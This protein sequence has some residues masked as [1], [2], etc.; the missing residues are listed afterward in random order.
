MINSISREVIFFISTLGWFNGVILGLYFLFVGKKLQLS[1]QL[2]G[3]LLLILSV[4]VSKSVIWYFNPDIPVLFVQIGLGVCFLIAP[5]LYLYVKSVLEDIKQPPLG[6]KI[7]F[8]LCILVIACV[9]IFFTEKHHIPLWK[10]YFVP[11]IYFQWISGVL[12]TGKMLIP[13]LKKSFQEKLQPN[14]KWL[15]VIYLSNL[16]I[17]LN[18][19]ISYM[20]ILGVTY[21]TGAITFS[22][23]LYLNVLL[24]MHRKNKQILLK[25]IQEKYTHKK[26]DEISANALILKLEQVMSQNEIYNNPELKL[27]DLAQSMGVTTHQLSQ[28][29]NDNIKKSF[30]TYLN[31][32]R[33]K[34]ACELLRADP[35]T[36][37]EAI[38]YDVGYQSKSTFFAAF[39][40]VME[41]TPTQFKELHK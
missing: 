5:I 35:T 19:W 34:K 18:Y 31:E 3:V 8:R 37:I 9:L 12:W 30:S 36:K 13:N 27:P 17:V 39:K 24:W 21:I 1:N 23:L 33:I 15:L 28:L 10:K 20:N 16:M 25:P 14:E 32:Y 26:I 4:R 41:M 40:K 29:L 22:L 7:V 38:A 11:L 6:W 2:F